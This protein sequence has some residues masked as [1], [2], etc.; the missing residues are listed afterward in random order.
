MK[1]TTHMEDNQPSVLYQSGYNGT[2][3]YSSIAIYPTVSNLSFDTYLNGVMIDL[4]GAD[5]VTID[6]RPNRSGSST[7]LIF[8]NTCLLSSA[9]TCRLINGAQNNT[10]RYTTIKGG[11][12]GSGAPSI[13]LF[14]TSISGSNSSNVIEYCNIS[15]LSSTFRPQHIIYSSGSAD[16]NGNINNTIRYNEFSNFF[17][18]DGLGYDVTAVGLYENSSAWTIT[19]NSFYMPS[20][21]NLSNGVYQVIYI[22]NSSGINFQVNNNFIGGTSASCGGGTFTV[23]NGFD[24]WGIRLLA[25]GGLLP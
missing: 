9:I 15:G 18:S 3:S 5:N 14:S 4:N 12:Y 21:T 22:N 1:I 20:S 11:A 10:I 23:T 7:G 13:I 16:P 8:Y 17:V 24:F 25:E 19:D 2:S 6:G